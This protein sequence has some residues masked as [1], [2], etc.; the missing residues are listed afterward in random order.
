MTVHFLH[1]SGGIQSGRTTLALDML[2]QKMLQGF[3]VVYAA[4]TDEQARWLK[5]KTMTDVT[6]ISFGQIRGR[7]FSPQFAVLDNCGNWEDSELINYLVNR[8]NIYQFAQ[9]ISI[10]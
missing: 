2:E 9:I 7:L 4:A 10:N 3:N 1:L 8:M 5:K 6:C